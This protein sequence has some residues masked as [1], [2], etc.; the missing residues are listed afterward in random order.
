PA[1]RGL[2][3]WALR[4][5][6]HTSGGERRKAALATVLVSRPDVLLLDEPTDGLD[7]RGRHAI[8]GLLRERPEALVVATH[9]LDV[10]RAVCP[11]TLVLDAGRLV[12]DGATADVLGDAALL[13][14]HGIRVP[15]D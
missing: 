1:P 4:A 8:V 15:L 10:V 9:D 14:R 12:A 11:R 7:A 13:A 5:A 2:G 3:A 6:H